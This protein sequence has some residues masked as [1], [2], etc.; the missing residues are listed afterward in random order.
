MVSPDTVSCAGLVLGGGF[1]N[2]P[3]ATVATPG[4]NW[5]GAP[6]TYS[7]RALGVRQV[8]PTNASHPDLDPGAA[9]CVQ[10]ANTTGLMGFDLTFKLQ[11]LDTSSPRISTWKVDYG[12]G[13]SPS[14]FTAASTGASVMTT[15]GKTFSNNTVNVDF[16]SALDNQS[17]PVWIRVVALSGST[18]SGNR[19]SS[20]IDDFNLTWTSTTG[21]SNVPSQPVTTLTAIGQ[22]TSDKITLAYT[23]EEAGI[24]T[25][26]L[27][28]VAGRILH[29]QNVNGQIGTQDITVN[30]LHLAPGVYIAKINNGNSSSVARIAVQ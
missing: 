7:N 14:S 27:Y 19:P 21:V 22:S 12:F 3:S 30:G 25:L 29:T 28:D 9:F 17:G 24:Y 16:G 15:G 18:G 10:L 6:P 1:K 8:S 4:D 13:A 11:S 2:F 5:C 23:V 20:A 26:A